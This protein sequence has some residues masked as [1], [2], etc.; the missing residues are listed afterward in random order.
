M[1]RGA[2]KRSLW[3]YDCFE[4]HVWGGSRRGFFTC[5]LA[6]AAD[7]RYVVCAAVGGW[8]RFCREFFVCVLHQVVV[9]VRIVL[10]ESWSC[11]GR[12]HWN[13][14]IIK[15]YFFFSRIIPDKWKKPFVFADLQTNFDELFELFSPFILTNEICFQLILCFWRTLFEV[16]K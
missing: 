13:D 9:P 2:L 4:G 10:C 6:A 15:L 1:L 5:K 7:E 11:G 14:C 8:V 16:V 12:S 3:L